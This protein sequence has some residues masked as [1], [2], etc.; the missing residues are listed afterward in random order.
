MIENVQTYLNNYIALPWLS[1]TLLYLFG[2]STLALSGYVISLF[3]KFTLRKVAIKIVTK[4]RLEWDN[5]L[6]ENKV[7]DYG[8]HSLNIVLLNLISKQYFSTFDNLHAFNTVVLNLLLVI[9]VTLLISAVI[10]FIQSLWD[11][12]LLSEKFSAKG[13]IQAAKL[14]LYSF[15]AI[16]FLS[17]LIG[18][19]PLYFLSGIGALT[20][21][22]LLVFKDPLMGLIAGIQVSTNDLIRIGD[23]IEMPSHDAN[24]TVKDI[25]LT[26]LK[27][28]NWNQTISSIPMQS[29]ITS[30]YKNWRNMSGSGG[31]RIKRSIIIDTNSLDFLDDNLSRKLE[32]IPLIKDYIKEKLK[33]IENYNSGDLKKLKIQR[34]LT[35]IGIFR[36][37]CLE[38]LKSNPQI[39]SDMTLIVRQLEPTEI[40]IPLEIWTYSNTTDW[41]DYE[42]IQSDVFDHLFS[43]LK[44]FNLRAYQRPNGRDFNFTKEE[45]LK[46][47][48]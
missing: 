38:Y 37:Y 33:E 20:A 42:G 41:I 43:I 27:V 3:S 26:T 4:T 48:Q 39:N 6:I 23:W 17:I 1:S 29:L 8:L 28:E 5:L 22:L 31:R 34:R 19:S 2:L 12:T 45:G 18:K 44:T 15:G 47:D 7:L 25:S 21:V 24:G 10:D 13:L 14:L 36:K 16:F 9:V 30:S 11:R 35:N 40:G 46:I 32:S